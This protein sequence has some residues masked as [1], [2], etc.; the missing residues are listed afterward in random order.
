MTRAE[1]TAFDRGAYAAFNHILVYLN[2]LNEQHPDKGV[3][4]KRILEM[5]PDELRAMGPVL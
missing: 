3:L 5:R 4:Y 1:E 2:T